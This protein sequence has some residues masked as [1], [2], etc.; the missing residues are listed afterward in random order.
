MQ[1]MARLRA[2]LWAGLGLALLAGTSGCIMNGWVPVPVPPWVSERMEEKY[3]DRLKERSPIMP[4]ILPGSPPVFCV[5][6]PSEEEAIRALPKVVRGVP[7]VYEE[8]RDDFIV[9]CEL[10]VDQIDPCTFV[11]LIGPAQLH[12]CH[13][14]CTVWFKERFQSCY[15]FPFMCENDRVEVVYIDKDHFHLCVGPD[16]KAQREISRDLRGPN[17]E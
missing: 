14:K 4:P 13:Y 7:F 3:C 15:P 6:P 17:Y 8:F 11:P 10:I 16:Q 1:G 5:D 2:L 12:H 9:V